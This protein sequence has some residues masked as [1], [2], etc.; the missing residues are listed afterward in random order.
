MIEDEKLFDKYTK[1]S[2]KVSNIIKKKIYLMVNLCISF[3]RNIRSFLIFRLGN[4]ISQNIGNFLRVFFYIF[5][6]P[7][8][9]LHEI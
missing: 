7:G 8:K 9:L 6:E 2:E 1:N 4:P 3:P 5:F